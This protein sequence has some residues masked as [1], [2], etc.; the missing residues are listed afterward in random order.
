MDSLYGQKEIQKPI[1]D[2]IIE[3]PGVQVK[4]SLNHSEISSVEPEIIP[5]VYAASWFDG[6]KSK[7]LRPRLTDGYNNTYLLDSGSMCCVWPASDSDVINKDIQLQ[8]VDGSPFHCYG[9]KELSIRINRK[10][11]K[12]PA[13]KVCC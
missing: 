1:F 11:Y 2:Q 7:D 3:D 9:K 6:Y 10:E 12:I 13:V 8:T 5:S 4:Q